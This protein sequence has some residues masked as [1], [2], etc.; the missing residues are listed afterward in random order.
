[1]RIRP[2]NLFCQFFQIELLF[3]LSCPVCSFSLK[4][5]DYRPVFSLRWLLVF[6]D[7]AHVSFEMCICLIS[8]G[9]S[10]KVSWAACFITLMSVSIGSSPS[11]SI[12]SHISSILWLYSR[13]CVVGGQY[14]L[15]SLSFS[16]AAAGHFYLHVCYLK[17]VA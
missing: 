4:C 8:C 13:S 17:C 14:C 12:S 2:Y 3:I 16:L 1:M 10:V 15:G 5:L 7:F 9:F 6:Q 11:W